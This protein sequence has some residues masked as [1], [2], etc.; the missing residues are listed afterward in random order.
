VGKRREPR[1]SQAVWLILKNLAAGDALGSGF[2]PGRSHAG[3]FTVALSA[4]GRR[5]YLELLPNGN[6]AITALGREVLER[7]NI[8]RE[9]E[10]NDMVARA[11]GSVRDRL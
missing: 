4:A 2:P 5:G 3:G 1:L 8:I 6:R 9:G 11:L 7:E 10:L